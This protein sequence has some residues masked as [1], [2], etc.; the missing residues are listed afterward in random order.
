M[1]PIR[2]VRVCLLAGLACLVALPASVAWTQDSDPRDFAVDQA[3]GE[4]DAG[5][6]LLSP[7]ASG[8]AGQATTAKPGR[9]VSPGDAGTVRGGQGAGASPGGAQGVER[10]GG[11]VAGGSGAGA[12]SAGGGTGTTPGAGE[13]EPGAG[14][15]GGGTGSTGGGGPIIDVE[16][17]GG[18]TDVDVDTGTGGTGTGTSGGAGIEVDVDADTS[19]GEVS[20]DVSVG[21]EPVIDTDVDAGTD[22]GDITEPVTEDTGAALDAGV[23]TDT[24]TIDASTETTEG[25]LNIDVSAGSDT[26]DDLLTGTGSEFDPDSDSSEED[27]GA[28]ND[29]CNVLDPLSIPEHCL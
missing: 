15:G 17:G 23:V 19:T 26:L 10:L 16:V 9:T 24:T 1:R 25:D 27:I 11:P 3:L 21:G 4:F 5:T 22:L 20:G 12:P 7:D 6:R 8:K 29:D 14:G 28:D 13:T 2:R 18:T